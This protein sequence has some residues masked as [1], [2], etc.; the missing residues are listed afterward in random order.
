MS[1]LSFFDKPRDVA[2]LEAVDSSFKRLHALRA[3]VLPSL[4]ISFFIQFAAHGAPFDSGFGNKRSVLYLDNGTFRNE[5]LISKQRA[6]FFGICFAI[7]LPSPFPLITA[8]T[9]TR[10]Q[11]AIFSH[12][13]RTHQL[14]IT[15]PSHPHVVGRKSESKAS[16]SLA[17]TTSFSQ[18]AASTAHFEQEKR[19]Q[20]SGKRNASMTTIELSSQPAIFV[21]MFFARREEENIHAELMRSILSSRDRINSEKIEGI[22]NRTARQTQH[23]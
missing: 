6:R 4:V 16:Y 18:R 8:V 9:G 13:R 3:A 11:A 1:L 14:L 10:L 21:E 23:L 20:K 15:L 2:E 5:S 12:L 17:R 22:S 7:A 19:W